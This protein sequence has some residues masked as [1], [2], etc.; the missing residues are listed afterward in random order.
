M[1]PVLELPQFTPLVETCPDPALVR[2]ATPGDATVV[3]ITDAVNRT[4]SPQMTSADIRL[5]RFTERVTKARQPPLLELSG[6]DTAHD[7]RA[8]PVLPKRSK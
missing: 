1:S 6:V 8:P 5:R 7:G 2:A 3:A 4:P